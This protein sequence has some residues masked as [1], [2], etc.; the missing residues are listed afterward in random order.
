MIMMITDIEIE[1]GITGEGIMITIEDMVV[2]IPVGM[3]EIM[4]QVIQKGDPIR[5][6]DRTHV[7]GHLK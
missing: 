4:I 5:D 6:Q 3:I 2:H 7:Q 1:D